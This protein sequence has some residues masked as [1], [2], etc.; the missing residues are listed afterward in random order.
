MLTWIDETQ[1]LFSVGNKMGKRLIID[2]ILEYVDD[3]PIKEEH[4]YI[5][6]RASDA[7]WR[8][9]LNK[10]MSWGLLNKGMVDKL[11]FELN[12]AILKREDY[13]IREYVLAHKDK[14][15]YFQYYVLNE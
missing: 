9:E 5:D 7:G 3:I 8:A 10:A 14:E 4:F 6:L 1:P 15:S 2:F 11:I 12:N 13:N